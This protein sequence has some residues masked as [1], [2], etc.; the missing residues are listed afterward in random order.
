MSTNSTDGAGVA[1]K[2]GRRNRV[3]LIAL[4]GVLA[5]S[6]LAYLLQRPSAAPVP[7]QSGTPGGKANTAP[8]AAAPV[9][10]EVVRL[11]EESFQDEASAVGSL[12]SNESVILR[13]EVSGRIARIQFKD[14]EQV[15]RG[16]LLLSLDAGIQDAELQQAK[17]NLA[18]A[19]ATQQ[20]N[21]DLFGKKFISQQALDN[22]RATLKVQEA[23]VALAEAKLAQ[24]R[25][26]APF[27]GVVGIRN[28]SQGDYIKEGQDLVNLED[29]SSLKLDFR[30]PEAYLG[31]LQPGLPLE[32]HSDA[33]A[34]QDFSAVLEAL[35]PLVEASGRSIAARARLSNEDGR[36]RPGMFVRVTLRFGVREHVLMLPEG[37]VVTGGSPQVFRI[38]D[39]KAKMVPVRLG[40]RRDGQVEVIEGL[41]AGDVVVTAG[42]LK[43]RD[44]TSVQTL[45][46][47][48]PGR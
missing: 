39:G 47:V 21:E 6:G 12:R 28:V 8:A 40:T 18:L 34:G 23:V 27:D 14:G 45:G 22:S 20:R 1:G 24:T 30:L 15:R 31:R 26:R 29:I 10:V 46:D 33:L 3:A 9:T 5:L 37:A 7:V 13:P 35:D 42:Q 25:I 16:A 11:Q 43:L 4:V 44:G 48:G 17:A 41:A 38:E 19:K 32:V 36:L 2:S